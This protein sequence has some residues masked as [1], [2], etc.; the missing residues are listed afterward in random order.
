MTAVVVTC[1]H[2]SCA[3][4]EGVS[5]GVAEAV[6]DTHHGWDPGAATLALR[7]A[8]ARCAPLL[9][10]EVTR[11]V[12]DLNRLETN[13]QVIPERSFEVAVPGNVGLDPAERERR[14]TR[15]HRPYRAAARR[16]VGDARRWG[17]R[18]LHLSTHSFV[19]ELEGRVRHVEVG[20]LFDPDRALE[21]EHAERLIEGLRRLGWDARAN[22]PYLGVA[23]GLTTWLR[24]EFSEGY[25]GIEVEASQALLETPARFD[26]LA[27]DLAGLLVDV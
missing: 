6:L 16:L 15:Y 13:P 19:P 1:E 9:A 21:A 17:G 10:G 12:V 3:V 5:L 22:Q 26:R 20:I 8:S 4:P 23:D 25:A 2:A 14:L 24:G 11:L 7:L 18:C 27:G